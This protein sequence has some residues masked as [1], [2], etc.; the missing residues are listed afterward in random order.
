[1]CNLFQLNFVEPSYKMIKQANKT[2]VQYVPS[3]HVPILKCVAKN[4][5][6]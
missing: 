3:E 6:R 1:M 5:K 4:Y 2:S